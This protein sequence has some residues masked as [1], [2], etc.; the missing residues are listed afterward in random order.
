MLVY[1]LAFA[2]QNILYFLQIR[3]N[4]SAI[5]SL[6]KYNFSSGELKAYDLDSYYVQLKIR[7]N[8]IVLKNEYDEWKVFP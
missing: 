4:S 1:Q 5:S 2:D 8:F 6:K 7:G 3:D